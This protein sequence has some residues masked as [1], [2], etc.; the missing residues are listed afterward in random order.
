VIDKTLMI[1]GPGGIGKGPIDQIVRREVARVDPYRLRTRP[2]DMR[3]NGGIPDFFYGNPKLRSELTWISKELGDIK[4]L[5]S[6]QPRVEW[7][8][9]SRIAFFDV[10][11][12]WQ[13]LL[14]GGLE[15]HLAKAEIY[16]PVVPVLF[17]R[18]EV[19]DLF[20]DLSIIILNPVQSLARLDGDYLTLKDATKD[21][22]ERAGRSPSEIKKRVDSIDDPKAP[23]AKAWLTMLQLGG[24]EFYNW[25]FPEYVYQDNRKQ[26]QIDVRR[27]LVSK[28]PILEEFLLSED[29]ILKTG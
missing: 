6:D 14:L 22:C 21:N 10:R 16:G 18:Q 25:T 11:G 29:E 9:K 26:K 24:H 1:F 4:Q 7:F 27:F 12:E 23:E 19:R 2:R 17:S 13:C 8:P 5:L 3:E 20:G 15:A 28:S